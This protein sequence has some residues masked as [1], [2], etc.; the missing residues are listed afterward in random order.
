LPTSAAPQEQQQQQ[1]QRE[2]WLLTLHKTTDKLLLLAEPTG[3]RP[4][5]IGYAGRRK[6]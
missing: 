6:K 2:A 4:E 5:N 1:Q 3:R